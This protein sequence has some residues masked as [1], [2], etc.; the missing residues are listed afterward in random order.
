MQSKN[1]VCNCGSGKK[2]KMCCGKGVSNAT[3]KGVDFT[4][5]KSTNVNYARRFATKQDYIENIDTVMEVWNTYKEMY[6]EEVQKRGG[7]FSVDMVNKL[8][9]KAKKQVGTTIEHEVAVEGLFDS[10]VAKMTSVRDSELVHKSI[11]M[12]LEAM[13]EERNMKELGLG[14]EIDFINI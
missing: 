6:V 2:Y 1:S 13:L 5:G 11:D 9:V 8:I 14:V 4:V 10:Y 12:Q 3:G 7:L